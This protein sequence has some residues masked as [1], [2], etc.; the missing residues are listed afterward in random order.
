MRRKARLGE[1][2]LAK[3]II[4]EE[5]LQK[6][7]DRQRAQGGFLGEALV[8]EGAVSPSMLGSYMEELTT[9]P[10]IELSSFPINGQLA[11]G[12]TEQFA[13]QHL[14]IPFA[15]W[16]Q[17]VQVAMVNP[18]NLSVVDALRDRLKRRIVP[19]FAFKSDVLDAI[20][21]VYDIS[22]KGHA[23]LAEIHPEEPD[24]PIT[25][26]NELEH[27]AEQAPIVRLV[28]SII[29]S[30]IAARASDIHIEP[31][32][33][34]VHVRFRQDGILY[35]QM[36]FTLNHLPAVISRIKIMAQCDISERRKPQ[37]GRVTVHDARGGS[38]DLRVNVLQLVHGESIVMRVLDKRMTSGRLDVLGMGA[39]Q[40]TQFRDAVHQP[41]GII[42]VTGPTGSGKTTTLY[43]G[44]MEILSPDKKIMTVED[45]VEYQLE[46]VNQVQ[47]MPKIGLDFAMCLRA[48]VRQDPDVI[49]IGEIRDRETAEIAIQ[50]ALTGH[51][52]LSTLHTNDAPGALVRLQNMGIEPFLVGSSLIGIMAQRL[53][54]MV[55]PHCRQ[56]APAPQGVIDKFGL[57]PVNG[58]P[59]MLSS[60]KGCSRCGHKGMKGRTAVYEY[61]PI[62]DPIKEL[63]LKSVPA[64]MLRAQA[65][66]EGM[67]TMREHAIE[68]VLSGIT[69][70]D[71]MARV[72]FMEEVA[73]PRPAGLPLAA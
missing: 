4:S 56:T 37:D 2:L 8:A 41:H 13:R 21:R 42:L 65:I 69:T 5:Q 29:E 49:L 66:A 25:N 23:A 17:A 45:P 15:E 36:T 18:Q 39:T 52:V 12:I 63:M 16:D 38:Y 11:R 62:T 46:G 10:Y 53:L 19:F 35:E 73:E 47:V 32:E 58:R 71:E 60:G 54:R 31:H 7:L 51:L 20:N 61:L 40:L 34:E 1:F 43:S 70:I 50:A 72:L 55:C 44:L 68:K 24:E 57:Q 67:T 48:L 33:N 27:L 64:S 59:P 26:T 30:A 9:F 6:S 22:Q 28:N 3:G 14:V